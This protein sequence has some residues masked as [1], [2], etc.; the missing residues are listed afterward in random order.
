MNKKAAI[1]LTLEEIIFIVLNLAFFVIILLFIINNSN[2]RP[3]YEQAY[4]KQIALLI[5]EAKPGTI[6]FINMEDAV[7]IAG[8]KVSRENMIKLV[9][10]SVR[11]QLGLSGGRTFDF[12]NTAKIQAG[13]E[14]FEGENGK[15]SYSNNLKIEVTK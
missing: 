3:V 14:K 4:A 13:F 2:G 5:D 9:G 6:I 7:K 10:N 1:E 15:I 12:F 11:V 8:N